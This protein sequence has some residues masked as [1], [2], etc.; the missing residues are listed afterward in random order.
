M[1]DLV[2]IA[3]SQ[4]GSTPWVKNL[5]VLSTLSVSLCLP[6]RAVHKCVRKK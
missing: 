1:H 5:K 2:D 6:V 4:A 3:K